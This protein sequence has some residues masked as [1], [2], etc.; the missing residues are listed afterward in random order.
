M[1]WIIIALG[2]IKWVLLAIGLFMDILPVLALNNW[3]DVDRSPPS[4]VIML[5]LLCYLLFVVM[6]NTTWWIK[7]IIFLLLFIGPVLYRVP[8]IEARRKWLQ[9]KKDDQQNDIEIGK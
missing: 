3:N 4:P 9:K 7:L 2:F 1:E 6:L 5:S 8:F